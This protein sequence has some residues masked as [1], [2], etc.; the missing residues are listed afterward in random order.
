MHRRRG[1]PMDSKSTV[2]SKKQKIDSHY[3]MLYL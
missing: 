3:A 1:L 2:N